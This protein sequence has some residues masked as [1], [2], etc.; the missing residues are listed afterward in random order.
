MAAFVSMAT[1]HT[2]NVTSRHKGSNRAFMASLS[3]PGSASKHPKTPQSTGRAKSNTPRTPGR[4]K[5]PVQ[6]PRSSSSTPGS[7]SSSSK[8]P[9][10]TKNWVVQRLTKILMRDD[11]QDN[12]KGGLK[13]FLSSL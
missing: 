8:P 13:D 4:D 9:S 10:K 1:C 7:G 11:T 12:K 2:C 3:T 5:T 6:T